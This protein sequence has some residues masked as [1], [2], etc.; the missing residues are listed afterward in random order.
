ML[1]LCL[2]GHGYKA[3]ARL[4]QIDRKTR[5]PLHGDGRSRRYP[6]PVSQLRARP[7]CPVL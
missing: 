3:M 2:R 6:A 7:R 5:A 1:Q 4:T